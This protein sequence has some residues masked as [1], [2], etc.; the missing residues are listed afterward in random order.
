MYCMNDGLC[1]ADGLS[2]ICPSSFFGIHCQN[3]RRDPNAGKIP[4]GTLPPWAIALIV[5]ASVLAVAGAVLAGVLIYRERRGTP[6]FKQWQA[7]NA[8]GGGTIPTTTI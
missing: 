2:C 6:V 8:A 4:T 1:S 7:T 5:I 3:N